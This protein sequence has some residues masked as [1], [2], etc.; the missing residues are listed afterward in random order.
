[1]ASVEFLPA[2]FP[3]LL[4]FAFAHACLAAAFAATA[5]DPRGVGGFFYHPRML[6]VVHLVTLG[7]ISGSILGS[8][9]IVGPLALRLPLPAGRLD[10]VAFGCFAVGVL[11]MVSHF[12][13][14]RP[15][16]MAWSAGMVTLTFAFVA[17]RVLLGL[18]RA[19]V[20]PEVK[21]PV[22]FAFANVLLVAGLGLL[23]AVNKSEPFL[24]FAQLAGA[25]AHAHLAV[26][27][28]GAMIVMGAGYRLIPM[29]LPA[30]MPKGAWS[31]ASAVLLQS[32]A[33]GLTLALLAGFF[34]QGAA[35]LAV[36]GLLAFF[37]RLAWIVGH[38]RPDPKDLPRPDVGVLHVLQSVAYLA[39]AAGTG[40]ALA[41]APEADWALGLALAYGVFGLVGFLAQIVIGIESRLL[42]LAAWLW[43]Y[44]GGGYREAPPSLYRTPLRSLQWAGLALWTAGVPLLAAGLARDH[45]RAIRAGAGLLSL[46]VVGNAVNAAVVLARSRRR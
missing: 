36:F 32:G 41:I 1:M 7:W 46:A 27:G 13:I 37:A 26:L 19:A 38:P 6:A 12:W 31:Y 22:A 43:S 24:P 42:P 33:L 20:P 39:L 45:E 18:R 14:D 30:A 17:A 15:P 40:L 28:F 23:L 35:I 2:R 25:I 10:H 29:I 9:Y 5:L 16:G 44:A 8:I 3:P 4:Y 21:L 11:G 34:V